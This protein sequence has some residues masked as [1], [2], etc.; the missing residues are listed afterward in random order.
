MIG[1]VRADAR[2]NL[3]RR[4][5]FWGFRCQRNRT[6]ESTVAVGRCAHATLNLHRTE[7]RSIAVHIRPENA[8]VLGRIERNAVE[9]HVDARV[10]CTANPQVGRARAKSVL[11]PRQHARRLRKKKRQFAS[12]RRERLQLLFL[13]VRHGVRRVFLRP[14][15]AHDHLLQL[16][17]RGRVLFHN[18]TRLRSRR[19]RRNRRQNR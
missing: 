8:L 14:N 4:L 19:C 1:V 2:R 11:A 16:L 3:R 9:R 7:Q 15:T 18:E 13:D 12:R 5:H 17:D 10:A 6:A